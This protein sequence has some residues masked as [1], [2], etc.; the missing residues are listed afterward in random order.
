MPAFIALERSDN[1]PL[2][3]AVKQINILESEKKVAFKILVKS[4]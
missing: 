1:C 4:G 2:I 3:P